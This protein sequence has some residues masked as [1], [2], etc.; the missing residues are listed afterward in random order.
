MEKQGQILESR[1]EHVEKFLAEQSTI[2][3]SIDRTTS[4]LSNQRELFESSHS[5]LLIMLNNHS[6]VRKFTEAVL[7]ARKLAFHS[8]RKIFQRIFR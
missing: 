2:C 8:S 1:F 4:S 5:H 7:E 3:R 6:H